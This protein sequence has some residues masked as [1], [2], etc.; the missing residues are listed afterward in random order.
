[1]VLRSPILGD[2]MRTMQS[3]LRSVLAGVAFIGPAAI[4]LVFFGGS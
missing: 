2:L 4:Y 3:V 1:M